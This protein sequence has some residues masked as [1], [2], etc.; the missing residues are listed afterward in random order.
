[1]HESTLLRSLVSKVVEVA[2]GSQVTEIRLAVGDNSH[3]SEDEIS[4]SFGMFA[5]GSIAEDARVTFQ[6]PTPGDDPEAVRLVSIDVSSELRNQ[7]AGS[8]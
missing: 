4:R 1:M 3:L 2:D 8:S 7:S 5:G 6:P